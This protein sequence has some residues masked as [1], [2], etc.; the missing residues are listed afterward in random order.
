[1][2][3]NQMSLIKVQGS[4]SL[5]RDPISHAIININ[6]DEYSA[7]TERQKLNAKRKQQIDSHSQ[8]LHNLEC[9]ISEIKRM[10]VELIKKG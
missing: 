7:Y 2:K 6:R 1:M 4:D 8:K 3:D 5:V 9:E 10:L